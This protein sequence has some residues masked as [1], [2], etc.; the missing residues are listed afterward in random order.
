M[1]N[2]LAQAAKEQIECARGLLG[3]RDSQIRGYDEGGVELAIPS[4]VVLVVHTLPTFI[5]CLPFVATGYWYKT[6]ES[7]DC[8][9]WD[10][11]QDETYSKSPKCRHLD[12]QGSE[13]RV[14][15][16]GDHFASNAAGK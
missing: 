15:N 11:R 2:W 6:I 5:S 7:I 3:W 9:W 1:V 13:N 12:D 4:K 14:A 16:A 10:G 8:R